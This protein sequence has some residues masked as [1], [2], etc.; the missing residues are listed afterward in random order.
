MCLDWKNIVIW[1]FDVW[2]KYM[3]F[4]KTLLIASLFCCLYE[5]RPTK[6]APALI[7]IL[8]MNKDYHGDNMVSF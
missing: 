3:F 7:V 8:F 2:V 5:I 6:I 1:M 4:W